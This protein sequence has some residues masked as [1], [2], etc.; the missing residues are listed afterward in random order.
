MA[1]AFRGDALAAAVAGRPAEALDLATRALDLAERRPAPI[2]PR[3]EMR[4]RRGG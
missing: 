3:R 2:G 4:G 1:I